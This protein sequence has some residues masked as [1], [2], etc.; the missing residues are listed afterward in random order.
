[1]NENKGT[2]NLEQLGA[3]SEDSFVWRPATS[4]NVIVD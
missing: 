1:M 2:V 3:D 4:L